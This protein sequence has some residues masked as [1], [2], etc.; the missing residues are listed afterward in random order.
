MDDK[1]YMKEVGKRIKERRIQLNM[2]QED[3]AFKIGY[4]GR[5]A[6]SDIENGRRNIS[7]KAIV[8][9]SRVLGVS[10]AFIMG[11]QRDQL[12]EELQDELKAIPDES[13]QTI[14]QFT[15][16]IK[17][18]GQPVADLFEIILQ[19]DPEDRAEI[20]GVARHMLTARKY[21]E[22]NIKRA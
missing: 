21:A 7:R 1:E 13:I 4:K 8:S 20:R 14:I 22:K 18:N 16:K 12:I 6:V 15:R 17:T 5:S 19:L 11:W 3:L 2:S 9:L 10:P